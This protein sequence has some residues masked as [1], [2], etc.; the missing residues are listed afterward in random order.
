[1]TQIER[2]NLIKDAVKTARKI[3]VCKKALLNLLNLE[4]ELK[5]LRV[6]P[7]WV[8]TKR[9]EVMKI[10]YNLESLLRTLLTPIISD[11]NKQFA[12]EYT[13]SQTEIDD[14]VIELRVI[15]L[16]DKKFNFETIKYPTYTGERYLLYLHS[17]E[18][19]PEK[20]KVF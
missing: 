3:I 13:I 15:E 19:I 1:V 7:E 20:L 11:T 5:I 12:Y 6:D 10:K 14:G 2:S 9:L 4:S 8:G 16:R 17:G 18:V